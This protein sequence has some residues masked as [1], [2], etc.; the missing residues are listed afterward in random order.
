MRQTGSTIINS[1]IFFVA[2]LPAIFF[3]IYPILVIT[4]LKYPKLLF[5]RELWRFKKQ[6]PTVL[7]SNSYYNRLNEKGKKRFRKRVF[8][9]LI[10]KKFERIN[11]YDD[12]SVKKIDITDEMKIRIATVA[13]MITFGYNAEYEYKIVNRIIVSGKDYLSNFTH[14]IHKGET[15][16]NGGYIALSWESF[17][18]GS[19]YAN[20]T[21]H[22]GIHEFA[23]A[24]FSDEVSGNTNTEFMDNI[25]H[26][27]ETV[28]EL[29]KKQE[30]HNYLRRYAFVNKMEFFAVTIEYFFE[31]PKGLKQ[32]LP[33]LYTVITQLL[34][35]DP[36]MPNNGINR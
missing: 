19:M 14:K 1:L 35:Q 18:E 23:H 25:N 8:E 27:H 13:V 10:Y 30:T 11:E 28:S 16:P 29:C 15:N 34:N 5:N 20:D 22:V 31:D 36:T 7:L 6:I 2:L 3:F 12:A 4:P 17:E 21:V 24:A 9:F 32:H 26:W 33:D